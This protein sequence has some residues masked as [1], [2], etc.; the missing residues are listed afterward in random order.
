MIAKAKISFK[1]NGTVLIKKNTKDCK[2]EDNMVST[3]KQKTG[4]HTQVRLNR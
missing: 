3:R 1:Y 2:I 4:R